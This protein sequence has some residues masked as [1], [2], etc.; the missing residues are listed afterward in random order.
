ML[1][2]L[3]IFSVNNSELHR[4]RWLPGN[5]GISCYIHREVRGQGWRDCGGGILIDGWTDSWLRAFHGEKL[6]MSWCSNSLHS[7]LSI[8]IVDKWRSVTANSLDRKH[9][10]YLTFTLVD[11]LGSKINKKYDCMNKQIKWNVPTEHV[12]MSLFAHVR[13]TQWLH[14]WYTQ[15]NLWQQQLINSFYVGLIQPWF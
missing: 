8:E 1:K 3:H 12:V 5:K 2:L 10:V 9:I 15:S 6:Y 13:C 11:C 4:R 7:S 14:I